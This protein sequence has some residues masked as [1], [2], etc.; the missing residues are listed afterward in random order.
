MALAGPNGSGKTT[1]LKLLSGIRAPTRGRVLLDGVDVR[2]LSTRDRARRVAVVSQHVNSA[3]AFKV[4]HLV[5]MG[6]T[7]YMSVIGSAGRND[8]VAIDSALLAT[9]TLHLSSRHFN[10]LS[11]GERQR[12]MLAMSLAQDADFLLLDE[13]TVHMDLQHQRELLE[14]LDRLRQER[15]IGVVAVMHDLNLAALY[16]DRLALLDRGRMV[17]DGTPQSV[18]DGPEFGRVFAAPFSVIPH[19]QTDV[20]QVLL[21]RD[22]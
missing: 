2:Q 13:P 15:E 3:I 16:F 4:R 9:D 12:V 1:L 20:P 21:R 6:R 7:P 5:G 19:P 11:G 14:T 22:A 8:A 18:I 17:A 10:E